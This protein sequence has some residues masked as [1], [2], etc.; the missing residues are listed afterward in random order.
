MDENLDYELV[1]ILCK[2]FKSNVKEKDI[3]Y[4]TLDEFKDLVA[5]Y[6]IDTLNDEFDELEPKNQS[7]EYF[8]KHILE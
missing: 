2:I 5:N 8:L 6:V 4:F 1:K 3:E 7:V